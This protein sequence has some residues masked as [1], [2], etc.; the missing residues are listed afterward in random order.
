MSKFS[1]R[2]CELRKAFP[3]MREFYCFFEY[4][5]K[6]KEDDLEKHVHIDIN[7][8]L[9]IDGLLNQ[10]MVREE[11]LLEI[12][13]YLQN[14][15]KTP[16]PEEEIYD[17]IKLIKD[18]FNNIYHVIQSNDDDLNEDELFFKTHAK[19]NLLIS[20]TRF[21]TLPTPVFS[22]TKP[23]NGAHFILHI[24]LSMGKFDTEIDLTLH[25]TLQES[26]R[27]CQLIGPSDIREDLTQ[28]SNELMLKYFKEQITTFPN[29][30]HVLQSWIV[31]AA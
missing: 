14:E 16:N 5:K 29:S 12:R 27:Y 2:P 7:Q 3:Q 20:H 22:Y 31:K 6:I 15:I 8:T 23:S 17:A 28:Y 21:Y 18:M 10:V 26:L 13:T 24:M 4:V 25:S 9:L 19:K 11:A 1:L 30:K